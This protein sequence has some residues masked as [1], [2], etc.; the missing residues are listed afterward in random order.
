E[1]LVMRQIAHFIMIIL[2]SSVCFAQTD[3]N[4]A[5]RAV[6]AVWMP[7]GRS[8][9]IAVVKYHKTDN[10]SPYFSKVFNYDIASKQ[11][12]SLFENGSNLAPSPDGKTIAFL[13]RD[14]N[15]RTGI[16]AF[17]LQ[18][19]KQN[20]LFSDTSGKNSLEWSPDG[21]NLV[22]NISYNGIGQHSTID[23]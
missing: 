8:L 19:K 10:K 18:T 15:K 3:T 20:L 23:I 6:S 11:T 13:K 17:D 21:K 7:D 22:Y 14:D 4:Y 5:T 12:T 16:Y 9:L 1:K 2:C